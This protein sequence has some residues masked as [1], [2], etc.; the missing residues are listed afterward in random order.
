MKTSGYLAIF[1]VT[2]LIKVVEKRGLPRSGRLWQCYCAQREETPLEGLRMHQPESAGDGAAVRKMAH[3]AG[4]PRRGSGT[5]GGGGSSMLSAPTLGNS[6][7]SSDEYHS[8]LLIQPPPLAGSSSP[9]PQHPPQSLN[10]LSQSQMQ[11]QSSTAVGAQIKK[12]S[13]FQIT[14]VMPAQVSV[15][16]NN[17]IAEDTES[18]DD[19]D[20]S[21]TE[22][23]SSS[24]ILDVS[25]SRATDMGGAERSS[26]EETL[27]NFHEADTPGAVSPNQPPHHHPLPQTLQHGTLVNGTIHHHQHGRHHQHQAHHHHHHQ[28]LSSHAAIAPSG[29]LEGGAVPAAGASTF[30]TLPSVSQKLT[31]NVGATPENAPVGIASVLGQSLAVGNTGS[32][33]GMLPATAGAAITGVNP[34]TASVNNVNMLSSANVPNLGGIST[35]GAS[36]GLAPGPVNLSN[37]SQNVGLIQQQN[38][39]TTCSTAVTVPG[40]GASALL[41]T[42]VGGQVGIA[43]A[44]Q[45]T[46]TASA[47]HVQSQQ[48][49]PPLVPP[50]TA[51]SRFRVV[52]LDSSSEPFRKGRWTCMEYYDKEPAMG[53]GV[54]PSSEG[55]PAH[56]VVESMRQGVLENTMCSERESTSGS[57]ISST[58]STLSHYTESVGSGEMGGPSATQP[59]PPS[60]QEY[61]SPP[62]LQPPMSGLAQSV[63]HHTLPQEVVHPLLK[64][65]VATTVPVQQQTPVHLGG[66]QTPIGCGSSATTQQSLTYAQASQSTAVQ[67]IPVVAQQAI[68]FT[69]APPHVLSASQGVAVPPDFSQHQQIIPTGVQTAAPTPAHALSHISCSGTPAVG[70]GNS[71]MMTAAQ[72]PVNSI[73]PAVPQSLP[74]TLLQKPTPST[75]AGVLPQMLPS[76]QLSAPHAVEHQQPTVAQMSSAV[77][78]VPPS[79]LADPQ[80][81]MAQSNPPVQNSVGVGLVPGQGAQPA[82]STQYAGP[83]SVTA[84]QLE[85]AQRLLLQHQ[86]LLSLPKVATGECASESGASMGPEGSSEASA[87]TTSA[88]LLPLKTLPVDGEED[89]S[90]G[91]SVVAIDNKIEQAMDLVKS[92]LMYAVREEVEVL[93]EQIK[94]LIERNSQLEQENNLLKNLASPEQLA[95]F[96]AQ[97]QSSSPPASTQPPGSVTQQL[98]PPAQP[99]SQSS[100]PSA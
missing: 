85:D 100:G 73:S 2:F 17:S 20:E 88:G 97:V 92:H 50:T 53:A 29:V 23:L 18:Y 63:Q 72:Q 58:I 47:P 77:P 71:P 13:G 1:S 25:L 14:S 51:S 74:S 35:S 33:T 76:Q 44:A 57:S 3:P 69:S 98:A 61:A 65:G 48:Q 38:T 66:L 84:A 54:P 78:T 28:V 6:G 37:G 89:S 79:L 55:V 42:A 12:K 5:S 19:L 34:L 64:T 45:L 68:G 22:D 62:T 43:V 91:A 46:A 31:A 8:N 60:M 81:G 80:C 96:Q 39:T 59:F 26:S 56:R 87:L 95:Q 15:S 82:T 52:K 75:Q 7:I 9:V 41:G 86:S 67:A 11:S 93:K 21:H 36:A 16:T 4:F 83:G 49:A 40:L 70:P 94:E 32:M 24:E 10:L 30:G 27:N 90:S 99:T